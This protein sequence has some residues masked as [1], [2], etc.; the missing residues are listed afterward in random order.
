MRHSLILIGNLLLSLLAGLPTAVRAADAAAVGATRIATWKDD[1]KAAFLLMFDD[2]MPSHVKN[3]VPEL[4]KRGMLGTFYIN[5]GKGEWRA[6]QAAWEKEFPAAGM[7][8][9]NHTF[10]HKGMR[11]VE[12]GDEELGKCNDV[13]HNLY[14]DRKRPRLISFGRPGVKKEDWLITDEQLKHLLAKHHLITR[15][16]VDGRF[17]VIHLKSA[18]EMLSKVDKALAQGGLECVI[19]HGVGGEWISAPLP[20]FLALLDG[21]EVRRDQL[22]IT[23]HISAHKYETERGSTEVKVLEA[24]SRQV[25][26]SLR[27]KADPQLYDIP[28]TLVTQVAADW[29]QCQVVQGT[30]KTVVPVSNGAV[31]FDAL[32]NGETIVL[33]RADAR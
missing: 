4:K 31:R 25:R 5:P 3:V 20:T 22:W 33:Q 24:N 17:A 2:S 1:K 21:L 28:L 23:D 26:L 16:N 30:S 18:E 11:S 15:P 8:Y 14:P 10:T 27:C 9:G 19:F 32:P 13:I 29:K 6:F 12:N 7:E